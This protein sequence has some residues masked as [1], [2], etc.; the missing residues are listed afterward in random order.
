VDSQRRNDKNLDDTSRIHDCRGL[1]D[2]YCIHLWSPM[3]CSPTHSNVVCYSST[4]SVGMSC[5]FDR[6]DTS[7]IHVD[8]AV[9]DCHLIHPNQHYSW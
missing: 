7:P 4:I 9:G 2:R 3:K 5:H 1:D 6:L 8:S